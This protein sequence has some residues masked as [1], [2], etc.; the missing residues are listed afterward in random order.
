[1]SSY[2]YHSLIYRVPIFNEKYN[3]YFSTL[4][5]LIEPINNKEAAKEH[6]KP[7][8][9]A[10]LTLVDNNDVSR[11][12]RPFAKVYQRTKKIYELNN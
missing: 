2:C 12:T 8:L 5:K 7:Y 3:T 4:T 1:M 9:L 11:K 6:P 10:R